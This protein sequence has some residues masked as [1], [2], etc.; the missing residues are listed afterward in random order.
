MSHSREY[1]AETRHIFWDMP[2]QHNVTFQWMCRGNTASHSRGY[3][4]ATQRHIPVNVPQ[5]HNVTFQ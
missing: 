1:A 4:A 2:Q 3:A 5:Q